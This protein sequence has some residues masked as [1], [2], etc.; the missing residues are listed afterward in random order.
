MDS[1]DIIQKQME[2]DEKLALQI[3]CEEFEEI[4][5]AN[6]DEAKAFQEAFNSFTRDAGEKVDEP[7]TEDDEAVARELAEQFKRE[8][9]QIASDTKIAQSPS[10][11][12]S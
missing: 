1:T 9:A 2:A 6:D 5:K 10:A 11:Y 12:A 4:E 7:F 8:D 3:A